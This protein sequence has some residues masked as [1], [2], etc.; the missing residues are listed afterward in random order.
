M[1]RTTLLMREKRQKWLEQGLT[2]QGWQRTNKQHPELAGLGGKT[3]EYHTLWTKKQRA[4]DRA[5]WEDISIS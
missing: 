2:T 4:A 3:R 1:S 5:A